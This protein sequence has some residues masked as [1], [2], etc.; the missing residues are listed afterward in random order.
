[1]IKIRIILFYGC[2]NSVT[3][4]LTFCCVYI[5]DYH[6][7]AFLFFKRYFLCISY[8][9]S[10]PTHSRTIFIKMS[11]LGQLV[12]PFLLFLPCPILFSHFNQT[13]HFGSTKR[14]LD[15]TK[16][17]YSLSYWLFLYS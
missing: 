4:L 14:T 7:T 12:S 8:R 2:S 13:N 5:L 10:L 16:E 1:M 9:C 15:Q 6:P 17:H 3:R 11:V